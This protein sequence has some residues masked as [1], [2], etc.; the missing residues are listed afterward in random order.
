MH[1]PLRWHDH[2]SINI[3]LVALQVNSGTMAPLLLPYLVALFVPAEM[4]NTYLANLRVL[5]LAAAMLAQPLAGLLSDRSTSRFGRR[6]PY[7][8][9]GTVFSLLFLA[10]VGASPLF[11]NSAW[12]DDFRMA[13]G[14]PVA[15]VVLLISS[16]LLYAAA[17]TA[18]GAQ[19]ALIPDLVPEE[20]RG[21]ASGVKT[22][23]ELVVP[24]VIIIGLAPLLDRGLV[25]VV[26]GIVM[27]AFVCCT[28]AAVLFVHEEPLRQKPTTPLAG[29][30]L[31]VVALVALFVAVTQ[32]AVWL[33]GASGEL[34]ARRG[35]SL[36]QQVAVV[37]LVGLVGMAGAILVGVYAG[38]RVALGREARQQTSFAWWVVNRLLF[39]TPVTSMGSFLLYYMT[40]VLHISSA[41]TATNGL[42][43]AVALS[44]IPAAL[45]GGYLADRIG[46]RLLI[47]LAAVVAALG[48]LVLI[49]SSG[50]LMAVA[51]GCIIGL[52]AGVFM[53]ANWALG[54]DLAPR[55]EAGRYLGLSNLAGAGAGLVGVGIGGPMADYF[56]RLQAGLG[57]LVIFGV[58]GVLLLLSALALTRVRS[59]KATAE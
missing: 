11:M 46:R 15:Y 29:P 47:A 54:T 4:K 34:L 6:R 10:L 58:Y 24:G 44:L 59:T 32:G 28:V 26:I 36:E 17:N 14:V 40:D 12:D 30:I 1:R 18:Q 7:M 33:V 31:R 43:V 49:L 23:L 5:G 50:L 27:A 37:G 53:A 19:L 52:A 51:S 55:E 38:I 20:Q 57:Y 42:M 8:V 2:V 45:A 39:L 56:N 22:V 16:V 13:L 3:Y 25:G 9:G 48:T 35:A 41:G 21:R